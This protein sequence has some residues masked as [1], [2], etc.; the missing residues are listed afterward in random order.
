[1]KLK[2][3]RQHFFEHQLDEEEE[4]KFFGTP[5]NEEISNEYRM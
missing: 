2:E 4:K 1:M 5:I 3:S